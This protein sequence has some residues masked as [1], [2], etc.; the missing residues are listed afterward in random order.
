MNV[1]FIL[2]RPR[3]PNNIG[4]AARALA[5]FGFDELRVVDPH[6]PIW[7]EARAAVGAQDILAQTCAV[8]LKEALANCHLVLGTTALKTRRARQ[9]VIRLPGISDLIKERLP[10]R[11]RLGILF[12]SEKTGLSTA[13]LGHCHALLHVPTHAKQLSMNLAQA[14]VV[15]AYELSRAPTSSTSTGGELPTAEQ[16][17]DLM[18]KAAA[19]CQAL[20]YRRGR[21][22]EELRRMFLRWRMLKRDAAVLQ[23]L[24]RRIATHG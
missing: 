14:V 8:S 1:R 3:D 10:H 6:L 21:P 22:P 19:A 5:N 4:A 9:P 17:D 12:G 7:K 24:F 16:L 11:G 23:G 20:G 2:V 13:E 15:T 18:T